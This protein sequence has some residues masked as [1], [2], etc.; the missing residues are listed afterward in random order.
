MTFF[1]ADRLL[2]LFYNLDTSNHSFVELA[3]P[4]MYAI[5]LDLST[6]CYLI[7]PLFLLWIIHL[8]VPVRHFRLFHKIYFLIFIPVLAFG[9]VT[10]LE[11]YHEWGYQI[12]RDAMSYLQFP[13]ELWA[14]SLNS[15]L[16]LLFAI[17]SIYSFLFLRWGLRITDRCQNIADE[18]SGLNFKWIV[19]N[20]G[21]GIISIFLFGVCLRGGLQQ[22]PINQSFA[23]YSTNPT[24]NAAAVNTVW[25]LIYSYSREAHKNP[26]QFFTKDEMKGLIVPVENNNIV[27][28]IFS[29]KN[30]NIVLIILES[31]AS[32]MF[33][34]MGSKNQFTVYMDSLITN[35]LL[36]NNIYGSEKRTDRGIV[37]ILS[38]YPSLPLVSIIKQP[39]KARTLSFLP[40]RFKK[41]GYETSFIYGGESEFANMKSYLLNAGFNQIIDKN[42]FDEKDMNSKWGAHDHV[43]F[44]HA[45]D[46]I[47]KMKVPFFATILTLS[48]HEPFEIPM[49]PVFKGND[50]QT[51]YKNSIIYLDRSLGDFMSDI[52]QKPYYDN[53]I[54]IFIA[55]HGF[56]VGDA[57]NWYPRRHGIPFFIYGEPLKKE[58]RGKV[59]SVVGSQIDLAKTILDQF[60]MDTEGFGFSRNLLSKSTGSAFYTF[61]HGFGWIEEQQSLVY[62]HELKNVIYFNDGVSDSINNHLFNK[63]RAYLQ[64]A[65]QDFI[66]R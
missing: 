49:A 38:G 44:N 63:G 13:K 19:K 65:Y 9:M 32:E 27:P 2:F 4:F 61:N 40:K 15:P 3:E 33:K 62:D 26:Y 30:N 42:N 16:G 52:S 8:F 31:T 50:R 51:L 1:A 23:Y 18:A 39:D 11:I 66:D 10:G 41:V 37:S 6:V 58:W 36:F 7:F 14:S 47:K 45:L 34:S 20:G 57:I 59:V 28:Q 22:A 53:T 12:N 64:N 55:D 21:V 56:R 24:M 17:Y 43:V 60:S 29:G 5:R 48:S 46:E 54:F 25:N 35:G